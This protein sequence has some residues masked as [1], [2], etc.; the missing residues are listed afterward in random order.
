MMTVV[1]TTGLLCSLASAVTNIYVGGDADGYDADYAVSAL[2][3]P[4]A[5]NAAGAT[6]VLATTAWLNGTLLSTGSAET[7]VYVYWGNT[8]GVTNKTV[9]AQVL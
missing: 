3:Y 5:N 1:L 2:E 8:D 9:W 4:Y 6:G 7:T